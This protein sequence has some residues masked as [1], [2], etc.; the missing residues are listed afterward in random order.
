[1]LRSSSVSGITNVKTNKNIQI[2]VC[3]LPLTVTICKCKKIS[4]LHTKNI[5]ISIIKS[6]AT[7][8]LTIYILDNT[9]QDTC[10]PEQHNFVHVHP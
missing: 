5:T 6:Q 8:Y 1:M 3:Y 2:H 9:N 7:S 10:T 4:F